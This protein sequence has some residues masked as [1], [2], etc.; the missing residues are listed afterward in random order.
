M[1][2]HRFEPEQRSYPQSWLLLDVVDRRPRLLGQEVVDLSP[3]AIELRHVVRELRAFAEQRERWL[4][5]SEEP[6]LSRLGQ[7]HRRAL[8]F[9]PSLAYC[10]EH[11]PSESLHGGRPFRHLA[12]RLASGRLTPATSAEIGLYFYGR[13]SATFGFTAPNS[14]HGYI[15]VAWEPMEPSDVR[16]LLER[17]VGEEER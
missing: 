10:V 8:S 4:A 7:G 6:V 3:G 2:L 17:E 16:W 12:L 15:G 1:T 5:L 9:G 14:A 13:R 11:D